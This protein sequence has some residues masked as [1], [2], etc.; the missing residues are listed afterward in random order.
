MSWRGEE[1]EAEEE[2]TEEEE[3]E[4]EE[5]TEEGVIERSAWASEVASE[6]CSFCNTPPS[7]HSMAAGAYSGRAASYAA[8]KSPENPDRAA[9]CTPRTGRR[10]C[11][12]Q[13][14]RRAT[15]CIVEEEI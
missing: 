11:G 15:R 12:R 14:T 1:E 2:E 10:G 3:E 4:E 13:R 6:M 8:A 9:A 5:E 7:S